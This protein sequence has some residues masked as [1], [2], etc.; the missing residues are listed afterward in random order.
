[1]NEQKYNDKECE[2]AARHQIDMQNGVWGPTHTG[3][4]YVKHLD[5][6]VWIDQVLLPTICQQEIDAYHDEPEIS[7]ALKRLKQFI[8]SRQDEWKGK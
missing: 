5:A 2:R 6:S 8:L 7:H 3:P 4:I 1:M